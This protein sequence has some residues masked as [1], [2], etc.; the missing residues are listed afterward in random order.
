MRCVMFDNATTKSRDNILCLRDSA[1]NA[2]ACIERWH[3]LS[4]KISVSAPMP[5]KYHPPR[6]RHVEG[7]LVDVARGRSQAVLLRLS[8][9]P[10]VSLYSGSKFSFAQHNF[11]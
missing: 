1:T 11:S 6:T 4:V 9:P 2:I 7:T 3:T 10:L 8:M 5:Y